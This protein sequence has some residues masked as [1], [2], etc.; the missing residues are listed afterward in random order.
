M[1]GWLRLAI[2]LSAFWVGSILLLTAHEYRSVSRGGGP[3][4][5]FV[6]LRDSKTGEDLGSLSLS[7]VKELG[8]LAQEKSRTPKGDPTDAANAK[9][10]LAA[11]P[12]PFINYRIVLYWVF[13]PVVI[14]WVLF[15]GIRW[16]AAGFRKIA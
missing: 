11:E 2:F 6:H 16:V 3:R 1:N 9:L 15:I 14:F 10:L 12:V 4:A 13:L 5:D 8:E 7:E